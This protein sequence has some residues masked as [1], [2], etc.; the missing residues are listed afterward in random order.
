MHLGEMKYTAKGTTCYIEQ[1]VE[2]TASCMAHEIIQ[3]HLCLVRVTPLIRGTVLPDL[4]GV[5]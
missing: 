5:T 2:L 3:M 1:R 4:D